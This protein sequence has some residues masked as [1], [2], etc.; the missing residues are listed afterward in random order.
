M[1]NVTFFLFPY[2]AVVPCFLPLVSWWKSPSDVRI[3][4][5]AFGDKEPASSPSC[6]WAFLRLN[7]CVLHAVCLAYFGAVGKKEKVTAAEKNP[8]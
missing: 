4:P 3:Q 7:V 2:L 6:L 1:F 8:A 5:A